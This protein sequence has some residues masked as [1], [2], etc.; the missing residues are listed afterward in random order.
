MHRRN[1]RRDLDPG[2]GLSAS[3]SNGDK[4]CQP[5]PF[6]ISDHGRLSRMSVLPP[7]IA[8]R[9][10]IYTKQCNIITVHLDIR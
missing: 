6:Q 1:G 7:A 3:A 4:A 9:S 10:A 2:I 8:V 5:R